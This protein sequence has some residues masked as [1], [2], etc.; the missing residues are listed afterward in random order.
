MGLLSRVGEPQ[1]QRLQAGGVLGGGTSLELGILTRGTIGTD[2][3]APRVCGCKNI[4]CFGRSGVVLRR[5]QPTVLEIAAA[6]AAVESTGT[7]YIYHFVL[8]PPFENCIIVDGSGLKRA[9]K[10]SL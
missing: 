9:G 6:Y 7:K 10:L 3:H 5:H 1:P 2:A 4:G 8:A